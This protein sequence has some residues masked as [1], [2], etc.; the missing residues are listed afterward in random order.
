MNGIQGNCTSC[1]NPLEIGEMVEIRE[2]GTTGINHASIERG[3]DIIVT[4]GSNVD[5]KCRIDYV[6]KKYIERFK[7]IR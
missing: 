3:D 2:K 5:K 6:N 4:P 1:K 7:K